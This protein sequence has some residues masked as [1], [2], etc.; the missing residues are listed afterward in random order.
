MKRLFSFPIDNIQK[1]KA[2]VHVLPVGKFKHS[3]WGEFEVTL[4]DLTR[5]KQNSEL[6]E[7]RGG[8]LTLNFNHDTK[9]PAGK[10]TRLWTE[11]SGLWAEVELNPKGLEAVKSGEYTRFSAE[12][13]DEEPFEDELGREYLPIVTGGALTEVPFFGTTLEGI[14]LVGENGEQMKVAARPEEENQKRKKSMNEAKLQEITGAEKPE[15]Q[16]A[17]ILGWKARAEA[18][19]AAEKEVKDLEKTASRVGNLEAENADLKKKVASLEADTAE[20]AEMRNER[21][22]AALKKYHEEGKMTPF[23]FE[24][25]IAKDSTFRK[26]FSTVEELDEEFK[27]APMVLPVKPIGSDG[28]DPDA[29]TASSKAPEGV[30]KESWEKAQEIKR[31]AKREKVSYGEA[32]KIYEQE[33]RG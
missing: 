6:W 14:F 11:P 4:E 15:D 25:R 16:E 23:Q 24:K 28:H 3:V 32:M 9:R 33:K 13:N 19:D 12:W 20:I 5:A 8:R 21:W 30:D 7:S 26:K 18:A 2:I 29:K 1:N 31:I 10:F 17:K 27:D 22:E